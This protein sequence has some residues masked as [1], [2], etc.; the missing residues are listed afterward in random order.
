[1]RVNKKLYSAPL[2]CCGHSPIAEVEPHLA[3]VDFG[4]TAVPVF[5]KHEVALS[6]WFAQDHLA[7]SSR[8]MFYPIDGDPTGPA[9]PR[10]SC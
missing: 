8:I 4:L 9:L 5:N 10:S 3:W 6:W 2:N 1:M 7:L